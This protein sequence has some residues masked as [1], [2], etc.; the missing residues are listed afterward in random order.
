M[1]LH[2]HTIPLVETNMGILSHVH[3]YRAWH[4]C[5]FLCACIRTRASLPA[6]A[7]RRTKPHLVGGVALREGP[8]DF[9]VLLTGQGAAD[10]AQSPVLIWRV[11]LAATP[12]SALRQTAVVLNGVGE[13]HVRVQ[14]EV[15]AA[16]V[17][18]PLQPSPTSL[19]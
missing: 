16:V 8:R 1:K 15:A 2:A 4:A 9:E 3:V 12:V 6:R 14:H 18:H 17:P 11:A 7:H 13:A 10:G 5:T 19:L